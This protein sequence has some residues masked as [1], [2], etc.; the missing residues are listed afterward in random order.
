MITGRNAVADLAGEGS[1][2]IFVSVLAYKFEFYAQTVFNGCISGVNC[3]ID[4]YAV[5]ALG[6]KLL[7]AAVVP[8]KQGKFLTSEVK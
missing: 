8:I 2:V 1:F 6:V 4:N 5:Y 7:V 3:I